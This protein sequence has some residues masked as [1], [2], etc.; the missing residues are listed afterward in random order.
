MLPIRAVHAG[1]DVEQNFRWRLHGVNHR[2]AI[3]WIIT[4]HRLGFSFVNIET[5]LDDLIVR[6]VEAIVFQGALLQA[7]EQSLAIWTGEMEN[8]FHVDHFLHDLG[9][10]D[11]SRNS[12]EDENVDVRLEL[13]RVLGRID[14]FFP[15]FDRDVIRDQLAFAGIFEERFANLAARVDGAEHVAARAMKKARD[16]AERLALRAFA[17]AGRAKEDERPVFHEGDC[18]IPKDRSRHNR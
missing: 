4:E 7:S 5:P 18:F 8:F 3:L 13:V 15:K 10:A 14:R 16:R 12:V 6:V 11:I 17:A 9:L 1:E 2:D